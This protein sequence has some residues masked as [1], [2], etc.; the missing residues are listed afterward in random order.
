MKNRT[1]VI[2]TNCLVQMI[3]RHSR[4]R[5]IWDA[6]LSKQF[7]MCVS[8][9]I[10]DE[11]QEI[12]G[13]QASPIVAENVVLLLLNC[14]NVVCVQPHYRFL[15]INSDP[16]DNKF[17]DCAIVGG[18]DFIVS[19]D[20]HFDVLKEVPFPKVRVIKASEFLEEILDDLPPQIVSD[21]N[22]L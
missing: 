5:P 11:Y 3:S 13:A 12:I 10:L 18:A 16:D 2:D 19:D 21:D 4:L 6:F 8:N 9:E 17:V 15:L 20:S 22:C 14:R 7:T 1:V